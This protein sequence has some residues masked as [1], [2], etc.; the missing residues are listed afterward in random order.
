M[1]WGINSYKIATLI[2]P[3]NWF[4]WFWHMNYTNLLFSN[5]W[6]LYV[7]PSS[8]FIAIMSFPTANH[9]IAKLYFASVCH[10]A[11]SLSIYSLLLSVFQIVCSV[12]IEPSAGRKSI[13]TNI[14]SLFG[15]TELL[16]NTDASCHALS[17]MDKGTRGCSSF[18][19]SKLFSLLITCLFT[20]I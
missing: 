4:Q 19:C 2:S 6:M 3:V 18:I 9:C 15:F 7:N 14:S 1:F 5:F 13:I 16:S 11:F 17:L 10:P 8:T 20:S 12:D